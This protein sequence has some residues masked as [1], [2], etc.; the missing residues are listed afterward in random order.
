MCVCVGGVVEVGSSCIEK[1]PNVMGKEVAKRFSPARAWRNQASLRFT[2]AHWSPHLLGSVPGEQVSP[3]GTI[4][5]G[6]VCQ[7][8]FEDLCGFS[9]MVYK[10]NRSINTSEKILNLKQ[11]SHTL[12]EGQSVLSKAL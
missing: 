6:Y 12:F 11:L 5:L 3:Q 7:L 4:W 1:F 2:A 8:C 10:D 9:T